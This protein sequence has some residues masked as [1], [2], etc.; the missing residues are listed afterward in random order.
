M[1]V[2][3][4]LDEVAAKSPIACWFKMELPFVTTIQQQQLDSQLRDR[5]LVYWVLART[6]PK[7][8]RENLR[9]FLATVAAEC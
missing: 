1:D 7:P 8:N 5:R 3:Q 9:A 2:T 4:D 6:V